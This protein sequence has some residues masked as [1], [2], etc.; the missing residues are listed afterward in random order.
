MF[1]L[2]RCA[3]AIAAVYALSPV[4]DPLP[5]PPPLPAPAQDAA[6]AW[7]SLPEPARQAIL[8]GLAREASERAR[9][10]LP[11]GPGEGETRPL[12]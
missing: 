7:S 6:R 10:A 5:T 12:R 8:D 11:P 2:L 9:A 3:A 1:P 4:R